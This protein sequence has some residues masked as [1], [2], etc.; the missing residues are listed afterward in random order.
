MKTKQ[1]IARTALAMLLIAPCFSQNVPDFTKNEARA[2][3]HAE[4]SGNGSQTSKQT[5]T[6]ISDGKRT[7]KTTI[8]ERNGVREEKREVTDENGRTIAEN[9][10]NDPKENSGDAPANSQQ[11][12]L[13]IGVHVKAADAALREQLDL[14]EDEGVVIEFIADNSPSARAKMKVNDI[15]LSL[16]EEKIGDPQ[17]LRKHLQSKQEGDEIKVDYLRKGQKATV[18]IRVE[19]RPANEKNDAPPA[20]KPFKLEPRAGRADLEIRHA[21]SFDKILEDPNLPENMKKTV[22]EMQER[23]KE[24]Q[25]RH[26]AR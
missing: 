7:I 18:T 17:E 9:P 4:A 13:W 3:A 25:E 6:V 5:V 19:K 12:D 23:L 24:L 14:A 21:E 10:D 8:T 11:Q 26:Q 1:H 22:R 20:D 16:D 2:E 15:I